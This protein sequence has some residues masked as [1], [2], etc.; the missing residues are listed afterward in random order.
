M[1]TSSVS[2]DLG[3]QWQAGELTDIQVGAICTYG[4]EAFL[5]DP[6]YYE[7]RYLDEV[8]DDYGFRSDIRRHRTATDIN[9]LL[10]LGLD[11]K[12]H[13]YPHYT[14]GFELTL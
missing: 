3:H 10:V 6:I 7:A 1:S 13:G 12:E 8:V 5:R 11:P 14:E 9:F 4:E 2:Y